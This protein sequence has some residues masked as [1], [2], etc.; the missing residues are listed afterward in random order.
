MSSSS[1]SEENEDVSDAESE[2][3]EGGDEGDDEALDKDVSAVGEKDVAENLKPTSR[4]EVEDDRNTS[5]PVEYGLSRIHRISNWMDATRS[6]L[7]ILNALSEGGMLKSH[8]KTSAAASSGVKEGGIVAKTRWRRIV[9]PPSAKYY[10]VNLDT[11]EKFWE[12]VNDAHW[13]FCDGR[14]EGWSFWEH[15]LTKERCFLGHPTRWVVA[16]SRTHEK[17][18]WYNEVEKCSS[19]YDPLNFSVI[20][21]EN[22][23]LNCKSK[24]YTKDPPFPKL[25]KRYVEKTSSAAST[26]VVEDSG[27]PI[28]WKIMKNVDTN[29]L[30][31]LQHDTGEKKIK[32]PKSQNDW[33]LGEDGNTGRIYYFNPFSK[34]SRWDPPTVVIRDDGKKEIDGGEGGASPQTISSTDA[35]DKSLDDGSSVGEEKR[36]YVS[37]KAASSGE[38]RK[39]GSPRR[40][41][42]TPPV[43][44][45]K[46]TFCHD[47]SALS[48][49]RDDL[50]SKDAL[51]SESTLKEF[52]DY[53]SCFV[54][55]GSGGAWRGGTLTL[56]NIDITFEEEE[57]VPSMHAPAATSTARKKNAELEKKNSWAGKKSPR[58]GSVTVNKTRRRSVASGWISGIW[59]GGLAFGRGSTVLPPKRLLIENVQ[60]VEK[61]SDTVFVIHPRTVGDALKF[62]CENSQRWIDAIGMRRTR[63][64]RSKTVVLGAHIDGLKLGEHI[65]R[66]SESFWSKSTAEN[67]IFGYMYVRS[68]D[69]FKN[70]TWSPLRIWLQS[71]AWIRH[72]TPQTAYDIGEEEGWLIEKNVSSLSAADLT[73][74]KAVG[75]SFDVTLRENRLPALRLECKKS[76]N[77]KRSN[78]RADHVVLLCPSVA[79]FVFFVFTMA[80]NGVKLDGALQRIKVDIDKLVGQRHNFRKDCSDLAKMLE[81]KKCAWWPVE[82]WHPTW[83]QGRRSDVKSFGLGLLKK[84]TFD[85]FPTPVEGANEMASEVH[86]AINESTRLIKDQSTKHRRGSL[87]YVSIRAQVQRKFSPKVT[88]AVKPFIRNLLRQRALGI[89]SFMLKEDESILFAGCCDVGTMHG[90]HWPAVVQLE[91]DAEEKISRYNDIMVHAD[92]ADDVHLVLE[93]ARD[94]RRKALRSEMAF[95]DEIVA[96][97]RYRIVFA[98]QKNGHFSTLSLF[99]P[100]VHF[101]ARFPLESVFDHKKNALK[102]PK[103]KFEFMVKGASVRVTVS[104]IRKACVVVHCWFLSD[105]NSHATL[106]I[107]CEGGIEQMCRVLVQLA[108]CGALLDSRSSAL[109]ALVSKEKITKEDVEDIRDICAENFSTGSSMDDFENDR[110]SG[111]SR[112]AK[113]EEFWDSR[114]LDRLKQK[115]DAE[116]RSLRFRQRYF[117]EGIM[118]TVSDLNKKESEKEVTKVDELRRLLSNEGD[119]AMS[120]PDIAS[121]THFSKDS[122]SMLK[123]LQ[124]KHNLC[125]RIAVFVL[126]PSA[127][128]KTFLTKAN[129]SNVLRDNHLLQDPQKGKLPQ[130]F[131]SID[132][133]LVRDVSKM[134]QFM[135]SVPHEHKDI[136]GFSD[137]FKTYFKKHVGDFKSRLFVS[138]LSKGMNMVIPDTASDYFPPVHPGKAMHF[139]RLLKE[140]NYSILMT[141]VQASKAKC[142]DNGSKRQ[143]KEGKKYSSRA[144]K[145]SMENIAIL[146]NKARDLGYEDKHFYVWDNTDWSKK[147][148]PCVCIKPGMRLKSDIQTLSSGHK[149]GVYTTHEK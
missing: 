145:Y 58:H 17:V 51:E 66:K 24:K 28:V 121:I 126:G 131:V 26:A 142:E 67:V 16:V 128:G 59:N 140:H 5:R 76:S 23:W 111:D 11:D 98:R 47:D 30:F 29:E 71:D 48:Q 136:E 127:A 37:T 35:G 108:R 104:D 38:L 21:S 85:Y 75:A 6:Q 65:M 39:L 90:S 1:D 78:T 19:W 80:H 83:T 89:D 112:W 70:V 134:W 87:S 4:E 46:K 91:D 101:K 146:F 33:I 12:T 18:F 97:H 84:E 32:C 69:I 52:A 114:T 123:T 110:L 72:S 54:S 143:V 57:I 113:A 86:D 56:G 53:V 118:S 138:L 135:S 62:R 42:P 43:E 79:T 40:A 99:E 73:S 34:Q 92:A 27:K 74:Q 116:F 125:G 88:T 103:P 149:I 44:A 144:W 22:L 120:E 117:A 41:A 9:D 64:L 119:G 14:N 81:G 60:E 94:A 2:R 50:L 124:S 63:F 45:T 55:D 100:E 10:L 132:G 95:R 129:L 130:G 107:Q 102:S 133:G 31:F 137:L 61:I 20:P 109:L 148:T 13:K 93:D 7:A 139:L 147:P 105:T 141:A 15:D 36:L 96:N 106:K 68:K 122:D 3:E 25:A 49:S 8:K 77:R 115:I 82:F